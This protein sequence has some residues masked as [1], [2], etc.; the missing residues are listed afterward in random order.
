MVRPILLVTAAILGLSGAVV[1]RG[2][3]PDAPGTPSVTLIPSHVER[4]SEMLSPREQKALIDEYCVTCHDNDK[5]K[6][7][8][9]LEKFDPARPEANA[10][11]TEKMIRKLRAGMM[12]PGGAERPEPQ[13]LAAL[14]ASLEAKIDASAASRPN[15]GRR[16]FQRLNRAE[17]ANSIREILGVD[18]DADAFL[19]PDTISHNFDNIADVQSLS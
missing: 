1:V 7:G 9:S 2:S 5:E 6:G 10:E 8:L 18:I 14:A 17:Y 4:S 12:P 11:V 19:P 3:S 15:P 13:A 16:T